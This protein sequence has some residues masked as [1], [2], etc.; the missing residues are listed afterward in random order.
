MT[1]FPANPAEGESAPAAQPVRVI[2]PPIAPTVTYT[3]IGLT[4]AVYILQVLSVALLGYASPQNQI[5]WLQ[6]YGARFNAAIRAGEIWRFITPVLL[7]GSIAHIFF[8]MY[9]LYSIGSLLER[10]FGHARFLSLYLLAGF[11]GNVVSFLLTGENGFSVGASTSVFGLAAAEVA[12]FYH[13]RKLFGGHAR[14]AITNAGV[15]IAINLFIGLSPGIDNWG[16][17]GGLLGG[18]MFAWFASP[19]WELTGFAPEFHL[20]DSREFGGIVLGAGAVL[21]VFGAL[22]AWGMFFK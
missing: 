21:L 11:S 13:N 1:E 14:S 9:A 18:A 12:F 4:V 10:H 15:I 22:A 6:L 2:L 19:L 8:N 7:H 5:D 17:I 20:Q 3:I 16:H